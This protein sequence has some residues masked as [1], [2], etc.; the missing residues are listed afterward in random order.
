[1][2]WIGT[3]LSYIR[4]HVEIL[5]LGK[6]FSL[7]RSN[8]HSWSTFTGITA[9]SLEQVPIFLRVTRDKLSKSEWK[10][11]VLCEGP[12]K[13]PPADFCQPEFYPVNAASN[14]EVKAYNLFLNPHPVWH[15]DICRAA[16]TAFTMSSLVR[17]ESFADTTIDVFQGDE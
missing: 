10:L 13:L 8:N 16:S 14:N 3:I 12:A 15:Y 17:S 4:E 9:M 1:M 5:L 2:V 11:T 6:K 7:Q